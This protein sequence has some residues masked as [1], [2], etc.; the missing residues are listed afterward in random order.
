MVGCFAGQIEAGA[1][2]AESLA[3]VLLFDT[4][5]VE[6]LTAVQE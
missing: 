3:R 4:L 5:R 1:T 6:G 2:V